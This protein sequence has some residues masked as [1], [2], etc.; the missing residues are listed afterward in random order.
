[1]FRLLS[2]TSH[3]ALIQPRRSRRCSAGYS[4]PCCTLSASLE[5]C[6]MRS[7]IAQPCCGSSAMAFR[8][9]RSSVPCGRSL[10]PLSLRQESTPSPVEV[11]GEAGGGTG[12]AEAVPYDGALLRSRRLLVRQLAFQHLDGFLDLRVAALDEV[13]RRV[14]DEHVGRHAVVFHVLAR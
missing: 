13:R 8:I 1:A 4:E 9:R 5:I 11:Q 10:A 6:W 2:E 14:V 12:T 7:A 3:S